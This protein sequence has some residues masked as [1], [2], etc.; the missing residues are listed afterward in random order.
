MIMTWLCVSL[1]SFCSC[2]KD[3]IEYEAGDIKVCIEEGDEWLHNF[4]LFLGIKKKN[5]PQIV[6]WMEDING[7][8]L[9]TLYASHKIATQSWQSAGD[10]RRKEALPHWCYSRGVKYEDGL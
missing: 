6:I 4:P 7:N 5:P 10:N 2:Q 9:S 8:Y 3:L 1:F